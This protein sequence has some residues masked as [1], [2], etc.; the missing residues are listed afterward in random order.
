MVKRL[1]KWIGNR[2]AGLVVETRTGTTVSATNL[3]R[4]FRTASQRYSEGRARAGLPPISI[5]PYTLR[6]MCATLMLGNG[7]AVGE[8]ARRL[9]H[10]P[11]VLLDTYVGVLGDDL[12]SANARLG[13]VFTV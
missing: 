8:A 12:D 13:R 3:A 11:K 1:R 5:T 9:G 10:S 6:H 2:K 7:V 4:A